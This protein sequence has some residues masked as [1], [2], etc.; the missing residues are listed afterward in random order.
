V[1][2]YSRKHG[3]PYVVGREMIE[4]FLR[5]P[6]TGNAREVEHRVQSHVQYVAV[7]DPFVA[8]NINTPEEYAA[9]VVKS[10]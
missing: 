3:H 10:S 2:E 7:E 9:M 4:R 6:A 8:L 5:E 1:P